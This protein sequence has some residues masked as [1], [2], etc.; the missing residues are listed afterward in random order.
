MK[1]HLDLSYLRLYL[2][3]QHGIGAPNRVLHSWFQE[4]GQKMPI[5]HD[6]MSHPAFLSLILY[7]KYPDSSLPY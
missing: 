6:E 4:H 3:L 5:L 7:C 2:L 1:L